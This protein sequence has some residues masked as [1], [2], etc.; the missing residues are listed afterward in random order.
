[1][2]NKDIWLRFELVILQMCFRNFK[3]GLD[4]LTSSQ[5]LCN[6]IYIGIIDISQE[7]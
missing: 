2:L 7:I 3:S 4:F 6:Y 1:M 5:V